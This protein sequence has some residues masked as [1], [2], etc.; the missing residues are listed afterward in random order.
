MNRPET[1]H[2]NKK[3]IKFDI[4]LTEE[5]KLAKEKILSTPYSFLTGAAGC[6]KTILATQIACDL[7]FKKVADR[8]IITRPTISTEDNGFLPGTLEEK[9][10]PWLVPIRANMRKIYNKPEKLKA[11]EIDGSLEVVALTHFRGRSQ[12]LDCK[13]YTPSGFKLMGDIE[14]GDEIICPDNTISKVTG[15]FPQGIEQVYRITFSDGSFTK[16][17]EN[18]LWKILNKNHHKCKIW[19]DFDIKPL[20][21]F[22]DNL[23]QNNGKTNY[24]KYRIPLTKPVDFNYKDL[25]LHPY[26]MGL[27]IGDGCI[28][29]TGQIGFT[30]VDLE[31]VDYFKQYL[32]VGAEIR[33][34]NAYDYRI[35]FPYQ[36]GNEIISFL[37]SIDFF[38]LK[39]DTK[40]IPDI[41]K[42]N[43]I[44]NRIE[45]LRGLMDSDG[46]VFKDGKKG[47][48]CYSTVSEKL[49][50]DVEELI[51][52]LGGISY[53]RK[54]DGKVSKLIPKK[55]KINYEINLKLETFNPFKLKRKSD[56][57]NPIAAFRSIES[58]ELIGSE[59]TKCISI[60]HSD[61]L[62]LTDNFIVT[63]NTFDR[64]VCIID[65]CQ[66]L[67]KSQ[68]QMAIGRLG[69]GSI[70]IFCGDIDQ[71]DLKVKSDSA[72]WDIE[73]LQG[74]K[75]VSI[76][77]LK[78]NHRHE[79]VKEV[80]NLLK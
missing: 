37:K 2:G 41:Y 43:S 55:S 68:L 1:N 22:K 7:Y 66:N 20:K 14:V 57:Y 15:V 59:E 69:K 63:H 28:S 49:K 23:I 80:L 45:L 24:N 16:C 50:N 67:S 30:T 78:E 17:S 70:M 74:S 13:V 52:S 32:P 79:A 46:T 9:M 5:Q 31:L 6:G 47:R 18:H 65:E 61:K 19:T 27:I 8:I 12:T 29:T 72:I 40:Y 51:Q 44:E 34:R 54:R 71:I 56:K 4:Q 48:M 26:L 33:H 3:E 77:E 11:M 10:D 76:I 53:T 39:S 64:A 36:Q 73:K 25:Y 38:F 35:I 42:Y 21:D 75:Y 60:E 62:Y 58:V